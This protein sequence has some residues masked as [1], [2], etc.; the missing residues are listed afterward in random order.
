MISF[1]CPACGQK[2]RVA[3][4][5]GGKAGK[6]PGCNGR[7]MVPAA[8][9][10]STDAKPAETSTEEK[11]PDKPKK[12]LFNCPDCKEPLKVPGELAGK[13][14]RCPG[15]KRAI[16]VP[17][18]STREE[19]KPP[20]IKKTEGDPD[21]INFACPHCGK[22]LKV[23]KSMGGEMGRCPE[24]EKGIFVPRKSQPLEQLRQA[25]RNKTTV[26][27]KELDRRRS[28]ISVKFDKFNE[29]ADLSTVH[30]ELTN[31]SGKLIKQFK[32]TVLAIDES[33]AEVEAFYI[34]RQRPIDASETVKAYTG[35]RMTDDT[36]IRLRST[37]D[38]TFIYDPRIIE[39][40]DGTKE[41]L[42]AEP[43]IKL[44]LVKK[45]GKEFPDVQATKQ[46][47]YFFIYDTKL[48]LD[49]GDRM[50][51][52][53]GGGKQQTYIVVERTYA[54]GMGASSSYYFIESC[55][56]DELPSTPD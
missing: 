50:I 7:V 31:E 47:K 11:K 40:D 35:G 52:N 53:I 26:P 13:L 14:G 22:R 39:Y 54:D 9:N 10:V 6:C 1:E 4:K 42:Q 32:G 25:A 28:L 20:E 21:K 5:F 3:D 55:T 48:P 51:Q 19:P 15:C 24:C 41:S 38:L 44:K 18:K 27:K 49:K 16:P 34:S 29:G 46:G 56:P 12:I 45:F 8:S 2:I 30:F 43:N 37:S 33:G 23:P 36:K 17:V